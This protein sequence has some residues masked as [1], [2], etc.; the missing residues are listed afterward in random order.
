MEFKTWYH[1][2]KSEFSLARKYFSPLLKTSLISSLWVW[3]GALGLVFVATLVAMGIAYMQDREIISDKFF[4]PYFGRSV[5]IVLILIFIYHLI[6]EITRT[7]KSLE[8][9]L[10]ALSWKGVTISVHKFPEYSG[11]G[12]GI[13]I[14]NGKPIIIRDV[15]VRI[16]RLYHNRTPVSQDVRELPWYNQINGELV[17]WFSAK[18]LSPE[19]K[20]LVGVA[21]WNDTSAYLDVEEYPNKPRTTLEPRTKYHGELV[22]T[23][24]LGEL[25]VSYPKR[26]CELEYDENEV[27]LVL[28]EDPLEEKE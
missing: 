16:G 2:R 14:H 17:Q 27:H 25:Y 10:E 28:H 23:G 24:R 8:L 18:D 15:L 21:N 6:V 26:T 11:L 22:V 19:E 9:E 7:L 1:E 4:P 3:A 5:F 12:V 13:Q 20:M